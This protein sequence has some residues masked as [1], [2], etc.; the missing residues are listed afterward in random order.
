MIL[1]CK[2]SSDS[3]RIHRV[4]LPRNA[5]EL[6]SIIRNGLIPG[7]MSLKK[8][9]DKQSSSQQRTRWRRI[10]LGWT[11]LAI[12]QNQGS[13]DTR[14]LGNAFK[15]Q[16]C[17]ATRSLPKREVCNFT[18]RGHTQSI[19]TTHCLQLALRKRQKVRFNSESATNYVKIELA[20][21]SARS[22][23]PR[24]MIILRTIK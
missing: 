5:N 1:H 3:E 23:K 19:S 10:W 17:G 2:T 4:S 14:I 18:K 24:H 16:Y 7:G 12:Q 20:A 22:T 8:E 21:W 9:E 11:L 13:R 15:I 6:N